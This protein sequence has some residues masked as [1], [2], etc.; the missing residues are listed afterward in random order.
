[1][2][3]SHLRGVLAS[4]DLDYV[5]RPTHLGDGASSRAFAFRLSGASDA[6][7][8][9]PLCLS[10][11]LRETGRDNELEQALRNTLAKLGAPVPRVLLHGGPEARLGA[12]YMIS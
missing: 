2:L 4:P 11:T 12:S 7:W 9:G 5:R 6:I 3:L 1:M 8:S 10:M